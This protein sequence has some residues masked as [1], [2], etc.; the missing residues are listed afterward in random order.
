[1]LRAPAVLSECRVPIS[2]SCLT[3]ALDTRVAYAS[4]CI[5]HKRFSR[6]RLCSRRSDSPAALKSFPSN[7]L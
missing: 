5:R 3:R 7:P 6:L 2:G 1:V 4:L